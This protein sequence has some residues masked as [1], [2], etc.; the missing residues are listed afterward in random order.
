MSRGVCGDVRVPAQDA[1]M[2]FPPRHPAAHAPESGVFLPGVRLSRG[3]GYKQVRTRL[4]TCFR[5]RDSSTSLGMT[6]GGS[7]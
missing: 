7:E 4:R 6:E 1:E 5:L 3:G 2:A